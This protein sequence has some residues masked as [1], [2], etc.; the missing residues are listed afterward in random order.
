MSTR[1]S[2]AE[3]ERRRPVWTALSQLCLDTQLMDGHIDHIVRVAATS[4]FSIDDLHRIYRDE[5]APVVGPNVFSPI[6]VWDAFDEAWLHAKAQAH[7]ERRWRG[8]F[9]RLKSWLAMRETRPDWQRVVS[10]LGA[11]DG[12]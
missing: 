1:L 11:S 9:T 3:V 7:A 5:V 12:A 10:R 8:P 2:D 4:G 6:G